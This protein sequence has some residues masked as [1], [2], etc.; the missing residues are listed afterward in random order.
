MTLTNLPQ[1]PSASAALL[2]V[3]RDEFGRAAY[4]HK[5]HQKMIDGLNRSALLDKRLAALLTAATAGNTI[6]V[7]VTE[8]RWAEVSAVILSAVA[9]MLTIYGASRNRERLADQHRQAANGLWL[10]REKYIHLIGD[11]RAG[12]IAE[13]EGRRLRDELTH[14]A[15][16]IYASAPDTNSN[17]YEAAQKALKVDEELTFSVKEIDLLLP[18]ALRSA[19]LSPAASQSNKIP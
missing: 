4:S 8:A 6:G 17:A 3:V 14:Q 1:N 2:D 18:P 9:L 13:D 12:V 11:L 10:L 19:P 7:L 5:T 16:Q 15:S